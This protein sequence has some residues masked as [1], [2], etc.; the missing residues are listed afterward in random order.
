LAITN[1]DIVRL[2]AE[3]QSAFAA[4]SQVQVDLD[5]AKA[6]LSALQE[7]RM[8]ALDLPM[9]SKVKV[10]PKSSILLAALGDK[11]VKFLEKAH[12]VAYDRS[13]DLCYELMM[14]TKASSVANVKGIYEVLKICMAFIKTT[15]FAKAKVVNGW[16]WEIF[17]DLANWTLKTAAYYRKRLEQ[18]TKEFR[19][20]VKTV[21]EPVTKK[22]Q[23]STLFSKIKSKFLTFAGFSSD[24]MRSSFTRFKVFL[25]GSAKR[26]SF[27]R[28]AYAES[29]IDESDLYDY[30]T[31]FAED[32]G[33]S[34]AHIVM[35]EVDPM[36]MASEQSSS[37]GKRRTVFPGNPAPKR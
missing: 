28:K 10:D 21:I 13:K 26:P 30:D 19:E 33:K 15:T 4:T 20:T 7:Q 36:P 2:N 37:S 31:A 9:V 34:K 35:T 17:N 14:S 18:L 22:V 1:A 11:G 8:R 29:T 24:L 25:F 6:A 27:G 32:K 3:K 5:A 16:L 23:K 12:A